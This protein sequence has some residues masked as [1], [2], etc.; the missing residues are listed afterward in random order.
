MKLSNWNYWCM[1]KNKWEISS[2]PSPSPTITIIT[3]T[4]TFIITSSPS[5]AP[6]SPLPSSLPVITNYHHHNYHPSSGITVAS[7]NISITTTITKIINIIIQSESLP[8]FSLFYFFWL[9]D[10]P[11]CQTT[12]KKRHSQYK[13]G[14]M[15]VVI[16]FLAFHAKVIESESESCSVMSDSL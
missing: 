9:E 13:K 10:Y 1:L 14:L 4:I 15:D 6:L 11:K 3:N 7:I 16:P 5:Q 12:K 2:P 8:P